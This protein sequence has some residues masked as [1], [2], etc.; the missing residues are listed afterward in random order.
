MPMGCGSRG[1]GLGA[2]ICRKIG[3]GEESEEEEVDHGVGMVSG[4]I[5]CCPP[6]GCARRRTINHHN[7]TGRHQG[8]ESDASPL[9]QHQRRTFGDSDGVSQA[10]STLRGY[11]VKNLHDVVTNKRLSLPGVLRTH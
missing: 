6:M 5:T 4:A 2:R 8:S 11:D 1:Y 10:C 7:D 3:V 9:H